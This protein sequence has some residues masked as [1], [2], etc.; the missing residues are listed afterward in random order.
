MC[1]GCRSTNLVAVIRS[2]PGSKG[3]YSRSGVRLNTDLTRMYRCRDCKGS[4]FENPEGSEFMKSVST[5]VPNSQVVGS[6]KLLRRSGLV[7]PWEQGIV[8]RL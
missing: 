6:L 2:L 8:G 3:R 4:G 1:R 5:I 7:Y